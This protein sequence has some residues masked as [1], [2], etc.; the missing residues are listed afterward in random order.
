METSVPEDGADIARLLDGFP[1]RL[2]LRGRRV[3]PGQYLGLH[4]T[5]PD[6]QFYF[7]SELTSLDP[8]RRRRWW[9][10]DEI[11]RR[12]RATYCGTLTAEFNHVANRE[13]KNW[14][15]FQLEGH[16]RDL[17]RDAASG[18]AWR[19]GGPMEG[20]DR[21]PAGRWLS[22]E[23]KR[24][25]LRRLIRAESLES[26]LGRSF[27]S[28][29]RFGLEGGLALVPGL[30]AMVES[31][32]T[33]GTEQLVVGMAHRGRLNI[34]NAVFDKP[35]AAICAEMRSEGRSQH[36]VGDVRYHL[37]FDTT[38]RVNLSREKSSG[39][40][41]GGDAVADEDDPLASSVST[42]TT[43]DLSM[44]PNPSHLEAVNAVVAG[45]VR[46]RQFRLDPHRGGRGRGA[47]RRVAGL[48]LHGDA[49]F[50]GLGANAEVMQLQDLPDYTTG[51]TVH[52]VVNNQIG[53]TTVP[54]R[55]RSSPHPSD[56]AKGYGAPILHV[57]ADDPEAVVRACRL[58]ADWRS[59]WASDVV[60][61]LVCYRR[62][63]HNEQDDPSITLPLSSAAIARH[64][65]VAEL[66]GAKLVAEGDAT[67]DE[68]RAWR[69]ACET[70]FREQ[71][72]RSSLYVEDPRDWAVSAWRRPA[73]S[74]SDGVTRGPGGAEEGAEEGAAPA[75]DEFI[76]EDGP[77]GLRALPASRPSLTTT[78]HNP[79]TAV[80]G[81]D[82]PL[83][84][85]LGA[86]VTKLPDEREDEGEGA[87]AGGAD[88][89]LA[90]SGSLFPPDF[91]PHPHVR[92][93]LRARRAMVS[94]DGG[95]GV[96]W[97]TAE[98]LAFGSL[99]LQTDD[100]KPHCHVRL[101]GQDVE[102][103]TFN[104][105]HS[106]LYCARTSRAVNPLDNLGL[107][108]QDRF[109]VANSPLS[110]H[111]I[112]GFEYGYSVDAGPSAL[113]L[114]EAQ[115]GDFANNAQCVVDQFVATGEAK[116]GQ[117]SGL[118]L[119]LPH[120]YDG[121]G[122]DHSSAR[123]ERWLAAVNDDPDSLPGRTPRDR[124]HAARTFDALREPEE[125]RGISL[126][127]LRERVEAREAAAAA[128]EAGDAERGRGVDLALELFDE[129]GGALPAEDAG[130]EVTGA[131]AGADASSSSAQFVSPDVAAATAAAARFHARAS[132]EMLD[133]VT[134]F[135]RREA[136]DVSR[137]AWH[138]Y[139]RHRAR[140]HADEA[141]NVVVVNPSTPAQY[142]H[143][144][145]RQ[146]LAPHLKPMVVFSPKFLL[147]H[148]PCVSRL[149]DFGPRERF[150]AVIADGDPGDNTRA[151][152]GARSGAKRGGGDDDADDRKKPPTPETRRVVL[153]SGKVFYALSSARKSRKIDD[154][155]LIRLEQLH[156]F[157]HDALSE[158][159]ARYPN[160]ELVWAQE[161][162][163]NM[164]FWTYAKPRV[165]TALR[166]LA[167]GDGE[168][169]AREGTRPRT[170]RYVGRPA[171]AS[172]ATGSPVIHARETRDIVD[173]AL[174]A[175][176]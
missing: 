72:E 172:P 7:G 130:A 3:N 143:A 120:G 154:V 110:E 175:T 62:H 139:M 142:F 157:P 105:R 25:V 22:R 66:Y 37:G 102:R 156:P 23:E 129:H 101:S 28:A 49:A 69:D 24:T 109:V 121:Q 141:A 169:D 19:G 86:A 15:R 145:R 6:R 148:R 79:R 155:A 168:C 111:A 80:T 30:Q 122:P 50:C 90:T 73:G 76:V 17:V 2:T 32:A 43:M 47:Q 52:V 92:K 51:G 89:G 21:R 123:P 132:R 13:K 107:G 116:W 58:A 164:G 31:F 40:L 119:L 56:V 146:A 127:R 99:L 5:R 48:L 167:N 64:K 124:E 151:R 95:E 106:V 152:R 158:R 94:E 153:C 4:D 20:D 12:L 78:P 41:D 135:F 126:E 83:L 9:S 103:G 97:A 104:H 136:G 53:F 125:G 8:N 84:R 113:V 45:M 114:W 75:S 29:K 163:K 131:D 27:P 70:D 161:E 147:H 38:V 170:I 1:D 96:D 36:N 117:R 44:A 87:D 63:G 88:S 39:N 68:I 166:A 42:T 149:D 162:P 133:D 150:R 100:E 55:A 46:S 57:N 137:D 144:L 82:L 115:F 34:L 98:L 18:G 33:H 85:A 159:L 10:L 67:K 65:S 71:H 134:K 165:D 54:R 174:S 140:K 128:A 14:L 173:E 59:E 60:I 118:V 91:E 108:R 160:A 74:G 171:A 26:F 93:L 138:R 176:R 35:L 16:A 11:V 112:L 81:V 77:A 61:N